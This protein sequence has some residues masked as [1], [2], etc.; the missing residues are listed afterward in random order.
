MER[1]EKDRNFNFKFGRVLFK[2]PQIFKVDSFSSQNSFWFI[3][4]VASESSTKFRFSTS[5]DLT[6]ARILWQ[7]PFN[8][9]LTGLSLVKFAFALTIVKEESL[10]AY[11]KFFFLTCFIFS[12]YRFWADHGLGR[13]SHWGAVSGNRALGW[14]FYAQK[15]SDIQIPVREERKGEL[16]H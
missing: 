5:N 2:N 3:R 15:S 7:C 4:T 13:E 1:T 11:P 8:N 9:K 14:S 16:V 6:T 10:L 12:S